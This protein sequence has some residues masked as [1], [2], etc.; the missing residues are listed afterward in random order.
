M[1]YVVWVMKCALGAFWLAR[2]PLSK[3]RIGQQWNAVYAFI[4]SV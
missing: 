3:E 2:D 1:I 4:V